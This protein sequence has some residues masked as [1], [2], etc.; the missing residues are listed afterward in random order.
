[1][2]VGYFDCFSGVAGDMV[3]GAF[4]DAGLPLSHLEKELKKLKLGGYKLELKA[5]RHSGFT[6]SKLHVHVIKEPG[7]S[8][9]SDIKALINKSSMTIGVK[10]T[11]L[12]I[13]AILAKA[14]AHVH[15]RTINKVH[16]HEVGGLDSIIDIVGVAIAVEYFNLEKIY[17]SPLPVT[18]GR[19]KCTHGILPV[20]APATLEIIKGVPVEPAMVKDEIVTPTGASIIKALSA[21][22][23]ASPLRKI[24]KT[25][26][27]FGDKKYKDHPN[28]LRLFIG[29]GCPLY[30]VEANI[31]DMN[32]EFYPHVI[33]L[34]LD[35]GAV[36]AGIIPMIMKK[37]RPG[38]MVQVLAEETDK[39]RLIKIILKETTTFGVRYFPVEREMASRE[40]K[41][42][43]TKWGVVGVKVARYDNQ[44][45]TIAPEY[46]DCQ[47]IAAKKN[48]PIKD[49]YQQAIQ[50]VKTG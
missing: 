20:P 19:I 36:D 1:M 12:S 28:C 21:G 30:V 35:A 23:G 37:G 46:R 44:T 29:E 10:K 15:G 25:G 40:I 32:P 50:N 31:D 48:V 49:V 5:G 11:A 34:L 18:R 2:S 42:V 6:G 27:G 16:F 33:Q 47:K 43:K 14:E 39:K 7:F 41:K 45:T 24:L 26:Y 9:Y 17:S 8:W 13:F 22:Y 3:L 38:A 4:I